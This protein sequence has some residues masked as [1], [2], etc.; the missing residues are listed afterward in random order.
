MKFR[1]DIWHLNFEIATFDCM[2]D[3][4]KRV[5]NQRHLRII[6]Y[7][8]AI[9]VF[10][11]EILVPLYSRITVLFL[12]KAYA[13][14]ISVEKKAIAVALKYLN[15]QNRDPKEIK[16]IRVQPIHWPDASLGTSSLIDQYNLQIVP[17]YKIEIMTDKEA[18]FIH[19]DF[20]LQKVYLVK[21]GKRVA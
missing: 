7:C 21:N 12:D 11:Y 5:I 19:T 9:L 2:N 14:D 8:A 10:A 18:F 16:I 17:G 4:A 1:F 13:S 6:V 3:F 15:S 20:S